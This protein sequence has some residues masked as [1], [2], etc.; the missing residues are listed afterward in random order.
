VTAPPEPNAIVHELSI[1]PANVFNVRSFGATGEGKVIDSP[2]VNRAID[3]ASQVGGGTVWVPPGTYLSYSIRLRSRI[4]LYLDS[5]AVIL[6]AEPPAYATGT[7]G[8]DAPEES[9][10]SRFPYQ[11]FGHSHWHNSLIWAE[12]IR[13]VAIEGQGLIWGRGLVNGDFEPGHPPAA[14]PGVGN[15]AIA[16]LSCQNVILKDIS[17]LQAGHFAV[18]ATGSHNIRTER[19][20]V[21]TNRDGLNFDCC[22]KVSVIGC[23]INAPNDDAVS[24]KSSYALGRPTVTKDVLITDCTLTGSYVAGTVIGRTYRRLGNDARTISEHYACRVKLGTESSGAFSNIMIKNSVLRGCRGVAIITVD[25]G[26]VAG[27]T[28]HGLSMYD[29]RS[30]P[31]FVRLGA[32]LNGPKGTV[33]GRLRRVKISD[34]YCEQLRT[35]MPLI[36]SGIPGHPIEDIE[37][38]HIHMKMKGGGT[39]T[40]AAV[41]PPEA[42][43]SYPEPSGHIK[44]FGSAL[45]A[46]GLLARHVKNI[47]VR[48]FSLECV[49]PDQRPAVWLQDIEKGNISLKSASGI[50]CGQL[51]RFLEN[52]RNTRVRGPGE[53]PGRPSR[54]K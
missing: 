44:S 33:P 35:S 37:M 11:D 41:V 46:C 13:D 6:A 7:D 49:R 22:S 54:N 42:A 12:N 16:L 23:K 51:F 18:L 47:N 9:I 25:G 19:L 1:P 20:E 28:V 31:I 50:V 8:Y 3:V 15:K 29:V 40:M 5:G 45:P 38:S 30:A 21:D 34:V 2:A 39:A 4:R 26:V 53:S 10:A 17:L 48:K 27:V 52:V 24:L 14:R 43:Q 32:R 36:V